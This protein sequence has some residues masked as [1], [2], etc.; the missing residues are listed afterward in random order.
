MEN[1][2]SPIEKMNQV[3]QSSAWHTFKRPINEG[4]GHWQFDNCFPIGSTIHQN[5]TWQNQKVGG[6][7]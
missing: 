3:N 2:T 5:Q 1:N 7:L 6:N 4:K